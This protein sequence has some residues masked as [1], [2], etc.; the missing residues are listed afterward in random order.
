M[1][2]DEDHPSRTGSARAV[3][4]WEDPGFG[5]QWLFGGRY[6]E[7]SAAAAYDDSDFSIITLPHCVTEL[8]WHEW[9]PAGWDGEWIYRRHFRLPS[10]LQ[11][12]RLL[13]EFEGVLTSATVM[14]ND[15]DLGQHQ[16]GYLPFTHEIT[17]L[18]RD[19]DNVLSV[20]VDG[21]WQSVPP[22]GHPDGPR[23]VDYC[24]PA[25]IYREVRL[26]ALPDS[27][28]SDVFAKPVDVLGPD[29]HVDLELTVDAGRGSAESATLTTE[30]RDA[31]GT[32]ATTTMPVPIE[33]TGP[34]TVRGRLDPGEVNLWHVHNPHLYEVISTLTIDGVAVHEHRTRI[35][36]RD[37]RWEPDGFYLNGERLQIFGLNRHQIYPYVGHAMPARVQRR[38]AEIL[39]HDYG[40]NMVR[41]AHYPQSRHFLDAC[42]ELGLLVWEEPPGW[43]FL[44]DDD[45]WLDLALRDVREMVL[46][47]R[48][49]PSV[50]LWAARLNETRN[51][52]DFYRRTKSAINELDD[53]RQTSGSMIF[54]STDDWLQDVFGYDDYSGDRINAFLKPPLDVP[55]LVSECVGALSAQP[56]YRWTDPPG[57]LAQQA[58][59]HAQVHDTARTDD[60]Y[61]GVLAWLA[62]DYG[63]Q[64][65]RIHKNLK[66]PGVADIFR[67][68]KFAA[69]FYRSQLAPTDRV[70]IEPSF[71]W[72]FGPQW[73]PQ[74]PGQR[75]AIWSNCDRLELWVGDQHVADALPDRH[76]FPHLE[77]PPFFV[78]L[79]CDPATKPELRIDGYLGDRWVA[80]RRMAADPAGDR[81]LLA[82]D[83]QVLS[84]DGSDMTRLRF[85]AVD[86]YGN[87]RAYGDGEVSFAVDGPAAL[88]G[89]NPFGFAE[90]PGM[91]AAWLRAG[92]RRGR[93]RVTATH[94]RL[95][96]AT[97][98]VA[99]ETGALSARD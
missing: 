71:G 3:D 21:S 78:S 48:N 59:A 45:R 96:T 35:G 88:V 60:R 16:G 80:S 15:T 85:G 73:P 7:G 5:T 57:T 12:R 8:S 38:D 62:F 36:F 79:H 98:T 20:I 50:V 92:L 4:S 56:F 53:S 51:L 84:A 54:H 28:L 26:R 49:R 69:S 52:P 23:S 40:C 81:L 13:L 95:G 22:D 47:D 99:I 27:Y 58:I 70:I 93:V 18:V 14:I 94:P 97:V 82:A 87:W 55:Y 68:D 17:D 41:C 2:I 31:A 91:G 72:G 89:D 30:L 46:R 10:G 61:A 74:G 33:G 90:S 1:S 83:D 42:D 66:T 65:G 76:N 34:V 29:R 63:S 44:P 39:K 19:G 64:N 6:V 86:R 67:I 77:H 24:Q 25:G 11:G 37:A 9:D 43:Q 32:L 75:A